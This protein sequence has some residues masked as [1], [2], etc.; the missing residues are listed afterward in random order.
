MELSSQMVLFARVV[1]GGSFS[2]AARQL[3]HTPS[4]VSRQIG[5]LE[6]RLGVR[7]L[8]R[9]RQGLALT[10]AGN[11]FHRR[12]VDVA[13][14]VAE[15]EAIAVAMGAKPQGELR[16]TCTVAFGKAHLLPTLPAFLSANAELR[17]SLEL[18]DHASD[19]A[20]EAI[21]VAVRF[22]EQMDDASVVARRLARNRRVICAS[23]DYLMRRGEPRD[24]AD[25]ADHNCLRLSTV[26]SW[27]A[28]RFSSPAGETTVH[29]TGD[30]EAN[31]A[32]AI[33]HATLAGMGIARLPTYLVGADLRSGRL[34][35]VLPQL[36]DEAT[37]IVAVYADRR[38]LAP[39]V[40]V[41]VDHLVSHFAGA[42]PWD[43]GIEGATGAGR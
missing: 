11:A 4:A 20:A 43:D 27:N 7:L 18:T 32:D 8:N 37:D 22:S 39:K 41:F 5:L 13:N 6:D 26:E 12:C 30:F 2:A 24:P 33:Y 38:N 14:R 28:W 34:R 10:E 31:S 29:A 35:R 1:E 9:S 36:V 40:R 17:L 21:V 19:L 25:L 15:A 23:P 16:V 42:P 3:H